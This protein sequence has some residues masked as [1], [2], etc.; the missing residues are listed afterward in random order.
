MTELWE[1]LVPASSP[2]KPWIDYTHHKSWDEFVKNIAGGLTVMRGAKGEWISPKGELFKDRMIPVRI[3]CS[4]D[5]IKVIAEF[6]LKHYD[7]EAVMYYK[8]S[9]EVH[10]L[11]A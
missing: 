11:Y 10:F 3:A 8:I 7:E 6:T 5:E 2:G 4:A 1:I 9:N